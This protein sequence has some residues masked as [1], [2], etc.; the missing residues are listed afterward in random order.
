MAYKLGK[1]PAK[2]DVR[3]A[4]LEAFIAN[5]PPGPATFTKNNVLMQSCGMLGN[6]SHGDCV[7]AD[8]GHDIELDTKLTGS[9]VTI[10]D[11]T[12]L[13][14]YGQASIALNHSSADAG[15]VMLD[16]LKWRRTATWPAPINRPIVGFGSFD[17][18]N[19]ATVQALIANLG[20]VRLGILLPMTAQQQAAPGGTWT[21]VS[22]TGPG[23]PGSWGGHDVPAIGYDAGGVY[24]ITWGGIQYLTWDFFDFYVDESYG[25]IPTDA[26]P[27]FDLAGFITY[28]KSIGA[29]V[30]PD[31][32]NPPS[33]P[34]GPGPL[35]TGS[36]TVSFSIDST[37]TH[38]SV[39]GN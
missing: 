39:K 19:H 10:S 37:G 5:L 20:I 29:Y 32:P 28:L 7:V 3:T 30:G 4:R 2:H 38:W 18:R 33:P 16:F 14:F 8:D 21:L 12:A 13:A 36:A 24:V 34:P 23:A 9:P 27:G 25:V 15:L 35:L 11:A 31:V 26:P 1:A 6:D 17:H 22:R